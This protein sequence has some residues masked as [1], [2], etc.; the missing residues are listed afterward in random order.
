MSEAYIHAVDA[1]KVMTGY[2]QIRYRKA[3]PQEVAWGSELS[4]SHFLQV[5]P[6]G[7]SKLVQVARPVFHP[8]LSSGI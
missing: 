3:R 4:L 8:G 7:T 1:F 6:T 2:D 5:V